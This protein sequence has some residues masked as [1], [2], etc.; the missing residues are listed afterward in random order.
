M[1]ATV[2]DPAHLFP[3][4]L[5]DLLLEEERGDFRHFC[6]SEFGVKEEALFIQAIERET[7][8]GSRWSMEKGGRGG[9]VG[10]WVAGRNLC[11]RLPEMPPKQQGMCS[12]ARLT[13]F[14]LLSHALEA[15]YLQFFNPA[16]LQQILNQNSIILSDPI[17]EVLYHLS[18]K[19]TTR[20][21]VKIISYQTNKIIFYS[22]SVDAR[23]TH[24]FLSNNPR[25]EKFS[26]KKLR[27]YLK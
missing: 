25:F 20:K 10:Y 7:W 6:R 23:G 17:Y 11:E 2:G 18:T 24:K 9:M 19:I 22:T 21:V 26:N 4:S 13:S 27:S 8:G 3:R 1:V 14:S 12:L 5:R 16:Y 15:S